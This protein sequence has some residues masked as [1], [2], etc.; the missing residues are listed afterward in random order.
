MTAQERTLIAL[1]RS[2]KDPEYAAKIAMQAIATL[3]EMR[4]PREKRAPAI[5]PERRAM[6]Q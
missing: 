5:H 6:R 4:P 1:I 3:S 2:K